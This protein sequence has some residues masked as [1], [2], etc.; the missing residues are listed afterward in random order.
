M[1]HYIYIYIYIY[2]YAAVEIIKLNRNVNQANGAVES[3]GALLVAVPS[4]STT[5]SIGFSTI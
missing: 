1:S 3:Y 4:V 2:I 5:F